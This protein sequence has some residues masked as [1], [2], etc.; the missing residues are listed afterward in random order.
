MWGRHAVR[1][2]L[3]KSFF[4]KNNCRVK[5][6]KIVRGSYH[7]QSFSKSILAMSMFGPNGQ[8][9]DLRPDI[10]FEMTVFQISPLKQTAVRCRVQCVFGLGIEVYGHFRTF[11]TFRTFSLG[12]KRFFG[13]FR[14][15][16]PEI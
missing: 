12:G 14:F 1:S 13:S 5:K 8:C 10:I 16:F 7:F 6:L 3:K 15:D 2:G 9:K 4:L 11:R